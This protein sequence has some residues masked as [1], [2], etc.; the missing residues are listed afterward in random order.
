MN[1]NDIKILAHWYVT[2]R[3]N[4]RCKT[5]TI[6]CDVRYKCKESS[7]E[8][9]LNILKQ[10]KAMRFISIDFTGGE[11]LLYPGLP[12][13][14]KMAHKM[15]IMTWLTT[16]ALLYPKYADELRG[17]VT[18]LSFSLDSPY[19]KQNDAI[20]GIPHFKKA[21]KAMKLAISL[22][23]VPMIKA[24]ICK[25][26]I[27]DIQAFADL[28][29]QLGVLIEL[30]AEFAYFGN[31]ALDRSGIDK[32]LAIR[33]HPNVIISKPHLQFMIDG[34]NNPRQPKCHIGQNMVVIAPDNSL[35]YPC[36]HLVQERVPLKNGSIRETMTQMRSDGRVEKV[37]RF[38]FCRGCTIPCYMES[39][40]TTNIDKY[41]ASWFIGRLDYVKKRLS[42]GLANKFALPSPKS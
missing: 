6:W 4:S 2:T 17:V 26:N 33:G 29:Q 18:Q 5:C 10:L 21:I 22:G 7:L 12:T 15:G 25:E 41:F 35:Y 19:Q 8:S 9:R 24:T 3:C 34:G 42:L 37:G 20:R 13:L 23:E 14:I 11:P 31:P 27:N 36:M 1:T 30:N 40:Y 39:S 32:I 38:P 16:N 28:A